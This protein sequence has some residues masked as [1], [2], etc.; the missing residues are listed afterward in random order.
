[1]LEVYNMRLSTYQLFFLSESPI[2]AYNIEKSVPNFINKEDVSELAENKK[3]LYDSLIWVFFDWE[4]EVIFEFSL[5][6]L[7]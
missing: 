6:F 2:C 7:S 4:V 3:A 1:M 5:M